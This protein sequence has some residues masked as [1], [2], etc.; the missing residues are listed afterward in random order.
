M[1]KCPSG[2][3]NMARGAGLYLTLFECQFRF[4]EIASLPARRSDLNHQDYLF[5]K[6]DVLVLPLSF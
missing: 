6:G 3:Q 5:L 2:V 4:Q 1:G